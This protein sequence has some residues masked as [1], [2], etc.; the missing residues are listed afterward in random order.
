VAT[1]SSPAQTVSV[2][3]H[4]GVRA[5]KTKNVGALVVGG[6]YQG[7]GIVRSLGRHGIPCVVIDDEHCISS[8]SR[9]TKNSIHFKSL[10]GP[11]EV[12]QAVQ[13]VGQ[14]LD[15]EGWILFATRDETVAAFS[16]SRDELQKFFRIPTTRWD[17]VKFAWDKRKMHQLLADLNIPAPRSC[18]PLTLEDLDRIDFGPPYV[19]KPAIKEHFFYK[20]RAKAWRANS[21]EELRTLFTRACQYATPGEM[22]VQELIPGD[23]RNQFSYCAFFKDGRSVASMVAQRLRQHPLEFGRASTYVVTTENTQVRDYSERFLREIDY[24]GLVEVELKFDARDN[25]FKLHDVNLRTWG[26]HSLGVSAGVDFSHLLY[27]DQIGQ[28]CDPC[29]AVPGLRWVRTV[30]DLPA[31]FLGICRGQ[32]G[33]SG[34]FRSLSGRIT[35]AVF[36]LRDPLPGIVEILLLPYLMY[37]RGF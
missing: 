19:L 34:Y 18:S 26:F 8:Y 21:R 20:T 16:Q 22:L 3:G 6:D 35:E 13:S 4:L 9:Y 5:L 25:Q 12:I 28:A 32:L 30:T 24:Y 33:I 14:K 37:K 31:S 1:L 10:R 2:H 27:Q 36:D 17:S 11:E 29:Q 15:L 7:L 23:G